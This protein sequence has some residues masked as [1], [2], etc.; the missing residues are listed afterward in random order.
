MKRLFK[1]F[2]LAAIA[3]LIAGSS[4]SFAQFRSGKG[5][6]SRSLSSSVRRSV[7]NS[8]GSIRSTSNGSSRGLSFGNSR[9]SSSLS[10]SLNSRTQSTRNPSKGTTSSSKSSNG[11]GNLGGFNGISRGLTSSSKGNSKSKIQDSSIIK[12][13]VRLPGKTSSINTVIGKTF[14]G[15]KG[16]VVKNPIRTLPQN[17]GKVGTLPFFPKGSNLNQDGRK[18]SISGLINNKLNGTNGNQKTISDSQWKNV[19]AN[20]LHHKLQDL[21]KDHWCHSRPRTCHWWVSYCRPIALC[22]HHELI[23]CDWNRVHC[24]LTVHPGVAPMDVQWYLGMKGILLPGKGIGIEAVEPGS[25]AEQVG[26]QPGMVMTNCNGIDLT[27]ESAMQEAIRISGGVLQMTLLS[28]D[29]TQ[30]LQGTVQMTRIAS[31]TF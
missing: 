6:G 5:G 1:S 27:D 13:G 23:T 29:G 14:S 22:H 24:P 11:R 15:G 21:H 3:C 17:N 26:L 19:V 4:E 10:G 16:P 25:P 8:T 12:P 30:V 28:A 31:V 2:A 9:S 7:S 20:V 18:P